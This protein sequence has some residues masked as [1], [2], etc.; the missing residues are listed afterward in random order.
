MDYPTIEARLLTWMTYGCEADGLLYW[1]V[2]WWGDNQVIDWQSPYIDGWESTRFGG[3]TGDGTLTYP[4]SAGPVSSIR[5]ENIRDGLEDYD[6]LSLLA[7]AKG[8][9]E[10][11]K[12]VASLVKSMTEFTREPG[13]LSRAL[14]AIG[15]RIE[16]GR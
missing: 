12:H 4:T 11:M 13:E 15:D 16:G 6:Y 1:H 5:L 14:E 8:R 9:D 2:N 3:M 7:D 10:A